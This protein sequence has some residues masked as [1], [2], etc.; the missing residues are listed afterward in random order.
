MLEI[1]E[2]ILDADTYLSLRAQVGWVRLSDAQAKA[3]LSNALYTLCAYLDGEPVGMGRIV[4]D[5]AVVSYVQDLVV[6]PKAQGRNIGGLILEKLRAYVESI[7]EPGTRMMLCLMC[8]K[9]R[10]NF[11][12]SHGFIARPTD[13]LGPGMIC[14]IDK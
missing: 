3:A 9:G 1:K 12:E 5:G 6:V 2:N 11:Y 4:G 14:Y 7:T 13:A 10:E 8:A